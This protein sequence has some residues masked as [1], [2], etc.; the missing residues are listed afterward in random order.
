MSCGASGR[1]SL[2]WTCTSPTS[3]ATAG[4][5]SWAGRHAGDWWVAKANGT[6]TGFRQSSG[7]AIWSPIAWLDVHVAD[8]NGDGRADIVGRTGA[9]EWWV[10]KANDTGT[11]FVNELWGFW[12]P[13]TWLDVHVADVTATAGPTSWDGR[14]PASGGWRKPTTRARAP[15]ISCGASGHRSLGWTSRSPTSRGDGRAD[16]VGRTD[17]G[18]WWVAKTNDTGTGS[19]NQLWGYWSRLPGP[20]CTPQT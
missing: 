3:V 1:R 4:P 5:T 15:S 20:T 17:W 13:I 7:G 8:V 19:V 14:T 6:G 2:G 9:G 12:S 16:I 10:A 11:G 18:D